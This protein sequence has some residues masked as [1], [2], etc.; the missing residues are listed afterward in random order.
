MAPA[1][2]DALRLKIMDTRFNPEWLA[3]HEADGR[4]LEMRARREQ[5]DKPET[6]LLGERLQLAARI[7]HDVYDRL[8]QITCPTLVAAGR[9]DGIAPPS[10]G[11]AIAAQIPAG[12]FRLFEGGHLFVAQDS[13]ALPAIMSFLEG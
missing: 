4:L 9:Y 8:P 10:N 11:Q 7:G 2:Q 12:E 1:E 3:T 5:V 6:A 13:A